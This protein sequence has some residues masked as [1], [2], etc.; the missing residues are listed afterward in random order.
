MNGLLAIVEALMAIDPRSSEEDSLLQLL[1]Q[2][3]ER[4]E[5]EHYLFECLLLE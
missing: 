2:L 3:I 1:V 5:E 4:F